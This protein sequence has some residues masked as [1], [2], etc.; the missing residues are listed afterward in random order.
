MIDT[1]RNSDGHS[2]DTMVDALRNTV[3][4]TV[5]D[6]LRTHAGSYR[7]P[8]SLAFDPLHPLC[9]CADT[10]K[11]RDLVPGHTH[12]VRLNCHVTVSPFKH[13]TP[14]QPQVA[15]RVCAVAHFLQSGQQYHLI[16]PLP[17]IKINLRNRKGEDPSSRLEPDA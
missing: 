2:E 10:A 6:T 5:I 4:G 15:D 8:G 16:P 11:A 3:M 7:D 13:P 12:H 1:L 14:N 9:K 17:K